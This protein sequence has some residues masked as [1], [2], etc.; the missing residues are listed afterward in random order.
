MAKCSSC[1]R[2]LGTFSF[3]KKLCQWCVEYDKQQRGEGKPE[4]YQRVMPTPWKSGAQ[5]VG[6][7]SFNQ[8][9][10]GI[11]L[12]VFMVM[13]VSGISLM[14]GPN[15]QQMI[16]WGG[17]YAALTLGGQPW[18]LV[19]YMFLHYGLIHIGFNMWCLW[20]LGALAES[21]YGDWTFAFVYLACGLGG[22]IAS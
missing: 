9:F 14:D 4:E 19:T 18:R 11:N 8:L 3:G 13:V 12:L 21:L 16:H 22:G 10:V 5:A 6:A 17:N 7:V 2:N 20:D 15:S 1:G